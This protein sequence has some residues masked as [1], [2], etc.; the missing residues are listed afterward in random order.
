MP[1]A[2][3]QDIDTDR[4]GVDRCPSAG[5]NRHSRA[6]LQVAFTSRQGGAGAGPTPSDIDSE[7]HWRGVPYP[8]QHRIMD[9]D[10]PLVTRR[11]AGRAEP[12]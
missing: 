11:T 8:S 10:R 6:S 12:P 2:G 7:P 1:D 5:L 3:P 9:S 4:F